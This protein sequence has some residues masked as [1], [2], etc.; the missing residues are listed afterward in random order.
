MEFGL[1]SYLRGG[2]QPKTSLINALY[3]AVECVR[4]TMI[5]SRAYSITT[6]G[7]NCEA[8]SW[9]VDWQNS[10]PKSQV[11]SLG[12]ECGSTA[13]LDVFPQPGVIQRQPHQKVSLEKSVYS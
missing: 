7:I 10:R 5:A 13:L 1:L 8:R 6:S 3:I 2:L 12:P 4:F 11:S 9:P